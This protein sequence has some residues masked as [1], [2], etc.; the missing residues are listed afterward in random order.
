VV[1]VEQWAEI[2]R[3]PPGRGCLDPGNQPADGVGS[4]D[5]PATVSGRGARRST[6]GCQPRHK[7]WT[8]EQL[9]SD[10][11]IQSQRLREMASEVGYAGGKTVFDDHVREVRPWFVVPRTFQRTVY[12]PGELVQCH[13]Q[14]AD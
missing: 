11:R 5:D 8:C 7:D 4:L 10:P 3:L 9:A 13:V 1:V 2:R 6:R 12:R 14:P